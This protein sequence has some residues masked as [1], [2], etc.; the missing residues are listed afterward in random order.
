MTKSTT[1]EDER[2]MSAGI[3]FFLWERAVES[4]EDDEGDA[5]R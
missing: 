1:M 5:D 2:A 4:E 3:G